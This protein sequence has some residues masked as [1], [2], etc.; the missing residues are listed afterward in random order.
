[1]IF[2]ETPLAGA[3]T[4]ALEPRK[5]ARG[6]FARAFCAREFADHGLETDFVQ[7]NLSLNAKTG[8]VRGMHFQTGE[9]AEVKLVRCVRGTIYDVIVD[10]RPDSPSCLQWFGAELSE[11]NGLTM[12]V[13]RGFAHGYQS[14]TE[15]ATAHYMVSAHY[16]PQSE[17]GV[18][19]DDPAIGIRWPQAVTDL[20][21]KDAAWPLLEP[22]T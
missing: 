15:G 13:P 20:S 4:I 5:D 18:R 17:S 6:Y 22:R 3:H 19:H 11:D 16:A 8:L 9:N 7:A 10:L 2:K 12:Y 1:M 21:D 14:L